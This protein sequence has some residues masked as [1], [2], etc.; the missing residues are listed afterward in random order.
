MAKTRKLEVEIT[1][2]RKGTGFRDVGNEADRFGAKITKGTASWAKSLAKFGAAA[3]VALGAVGVVAVKF[4]ADAAASASDVQEALQKS[5]TVFGAQAKAIEN[6]AD[7]AAQNLGLAKG[8]ALDAAG[9]FGNMFDQ[10]G[11]TE[12]ASADMSKEIIGLA[13]DFSSFHNAD[14][15]EVLEAQSAA[16]RGEYDSLQRFLPLMS[17]ATVEQ[18]AMAMT[19]K[20]NAG[21]LTAQEKAL[22]TYQLMLEGAGAAQGDFA[23]TSDQAANSQRIAAAEMENMRAEIGE[24]LLP[25]QQLLTEATLGFATFV[26]E[27]LIPAIE[28]WWAS[29]D[30]DVIPVLTSLW[31]WVTE[32]VVPALQDL[33]TKVVDTVVPALQDLWTWIQESLIPALQ[34]TWEIIQSQ[35]IP[36]YQEIARIW[37]EEVGP[38]VQG[39]VDALGDL[40]GITDRST[41]ATKRNSDG[42][43][44]WAAILEG[45]LFGPQLMAK[46][47]GW[48]ADALAAVIRQAGRAY[49]ALD[50]IKDAVPGGDG[51]GTILGVGGGVSV[52]RKLFGAEGGIVTPSG[53]E[54]LASGGVA[55]MSALA[56]GAD[57]VPAML[58]PGEMVL[59]EA[60]QRSLLGA[61]RGGLGGTTVI[62]NNYYNVAGSVWGEGDLVRALN[63]QAGRGHKIDASAVA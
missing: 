23:A 22:A 9:G 7:D 48:I 58:S 15:T 10:L 39:L 33:A 61:I 27:T 59:T 14:I 21:E 53:I 6:W 45:A 12:S 49:D 44:T 3:G 54:Y 18:K 16:F 37:V 25:V 1:D 34:E 26:T 62:E 5:N 56:R 13:A 11:L 60:D 17:A 31:A 28:D 2:S 38:A 57:T 43:K 4:G 30:Q 42:W 46:A 63:R 47:I 24:K 19:G 36:K 29:V 8:A 41:D 35:V 51:L 50:R 55:G 32:S 40:F 20:E 52:V